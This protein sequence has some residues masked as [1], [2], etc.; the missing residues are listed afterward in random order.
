MCKIEFSTNFQINVVTFDALKK[1]YSIKTD[2]LVII[3]FRNSII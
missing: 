3:N 1:S 2:F